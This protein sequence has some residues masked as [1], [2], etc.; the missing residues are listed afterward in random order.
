MELYTKKW[1]TK[2]F[3]KELFDFCFPADFRLRQRAKLERFRQNR[4]RVRDYAAELAMIFRTVGST[5]EQ[6]KVDHLWKGLRPE[7][8][9]ALW[10]E[11]LDPRTSTWDE[12]IQVAERHEIADRIEI[13]DR[14]AASRFN[15]KDK[16]R[17]S[18]S[19]ASDKDAGSSDSDDNE[20]SD[21]SGD[22]KSRRRLSEKEKS[23]LKAQGRCFTC[24]G[25]GH[26]ARDCPQRGLTSANEETSGAESFNIEVA[27]AKEKTLGGIEGT[28]G[29]AVESSFVGFECATIGLDCLEGESDLIFASV[30]FGLEVLSDNGPS[31]E[32]EIDVHSVEDVPR[33]GMFTETTGS[34]ISG[35]IFEEND[36]DEIS[37]IAR[38]EAE[39]SPDQKEYAMHDLELL[40]GIETILKFEDLLENRT[41]RWLTDYKGLA[42][43]FNSHNLSEWQAGLLTKISKFDF[44]NEYDPTIRDKL[45]ASG[46]NIL[47]GESTKFLS[48]SSIK[49]DRT[50]DE[51]VYDFCRRFGFEVVTWYADDV[52]LRGVRERTEGEGKEGKLLNQPEDFVVIDLKGFE[53]H[54][55]EFSMSIR[56][57]L[58]KFSTPTEDGLNMALA[59][60]SEFKQAPNILGIFSRINLDMI[61]RGLENV[62]LPKNL[63]DIGQNSAL[64][65]GKKLIGFNTDSVSDAKVVGNCNIAVGTSG[66]VL[67]QE[68]LRLNEAH[69]IETGFEVIELSET[70]T[71]FI[72]KHLLSRVFNDPKL[73]YDLINI[74]SNTSA[75]LNQ[76]ASTQGN[77]PP[78][79]HSIL[80]NPR[81]VD[82]KLNA[83]HLNILDMESDDEQFFDDEA[84]PN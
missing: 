26:L 78:P 45:V 43:L 72:P 11:N 29:D 73:L 63:T 31:D 32:P 69:D 58:S 66:G 51:L 24:K 33:M 9:R 44:E 2:E 37:I 35:V 79:F 12:I 84:S 68:D 64:V 10:R 80:E 54:D 71:V 39:L 18:S 60:T 16:K 20:S 65:I 19:S 57:G 4:E 27:A 74:Y 41:F 50:K 15:G 42:E 76:G 7:L 55:F 67:P 61:I 5:S 46:N 47:E 53:K 75:L 82:G 81:C 40:A 56:D 23:E 34:K 38:H 48:G 77:Y 6:E 17:R 25:K 21:T 8:Q 49:R 52:V 59:K 28:H 13:G 14:N 30:D 83:E 1:S 70:E 36:L 22:S 3:Y 62:N